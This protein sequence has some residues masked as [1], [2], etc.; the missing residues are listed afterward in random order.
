LTIAA[1]G[2]GL[3]HDHCPDLGGLADEECMTEALQD[4]VEPHS[5]AGA[6]DADGHGGRQRGIEAFDGVAV[7]GQLVVP[8][9]ARVRVQPR[10]LLLPRVQ[11]TSDHDHESAL[12]WC[13]VVVLSSAETPNDVWLFS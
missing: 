4:F 3:A 6:F 1:I 7:V 9:L 11:V 5:A 8:D 10:D 12:R 13:D 2:L